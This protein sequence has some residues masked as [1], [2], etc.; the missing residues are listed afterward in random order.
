MEFILEFYQSLE[1]LDLIIFW[2]IIIVI[3]L[4]IIFSL[5]MINKNKKLKKM[6]SKN[7][8]EKQ[9]IN[10]DQELPIKTTNLSDQVDKSINLDSTPKKND[11]EELKEIDLPEIPGVKK[12]LDI[13]QNNLNNSIET[14]KKFIAEEHIMEYNND[15]FSLPNIKKNNPSTENQS[16]ENKQPENRKIKSSSTIDL[17]KTPYERNVLREMSLSQ[18]SPIGLTYPKANEDKKLAM[19]KDLSDSLHSENINEDDFQENYQSS[20]NQKNIQNNPPIKESNITLKREQITRTTTNIQ[21]KNHHQISSSNLQSSTVE[22]ENNLLKQELQSIPNSS[23]RKTTIKNDLPRVTPNNLKDDATPK[24]ETNKISNFSN[25]SSSM[26]QPNNSNIIDEEYQTKNNFKE[27]HLHFQERTI[28]NNHLDNSTT[29]KHELSSPSIS[30]SDYLKNNHS[31]KESSTN[32]NLNKNLSESKDTLHSSKN[33]Q[34][35]LAYKETNIQTN[36][37]NSSK[38][39]IDPRVKALFDSI[40]K[41][42]EPTIKNNSS[43]QYLEEVSRK[44]AEAEIT[45]EVERTD[46]E[47]EQEENAII[48]YK[49]LMAKKDSIQTIDEEDAVIS[50]EELMNRN[51]NN[52]METSNYQK[53]PL[54]KPTNNEEDTKLYKLTEE[55]EDDDFINE[56]KQFRNDL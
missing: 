18:T 9:T 52:D 56:L 49:E 3:I 45:D 28:K 16:K 44:L 47:L 19:A 15:L 20:N 34:N 7:N 37:K 13:S 40:S 31:S 42:D 30:N 21:E 41:Q 53:E 8:Q 14:E 11:Q 27:D 23:S 48:S 50:I 35:E 36:S 24:N 33:N 1:T 2:G 55:E 25:K 5:V 43:E 22:K 51:Q 32:N 54:S 39:D 17:P 10:T 4:L 6:V 29:E 46:Y 12:E 38:N 26:N